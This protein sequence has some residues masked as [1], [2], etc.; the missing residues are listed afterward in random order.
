MNTKTYVTGYVIYVTETNRL[1]K[2]GTDINIHQYSVFLKHEL[3]SSSA[4]SSK[5]VHAG[6]NLKL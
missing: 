6:C 2:E 5:G 3:Q 4:R 1:G